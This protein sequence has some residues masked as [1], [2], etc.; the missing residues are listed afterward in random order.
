MRSCEVDVGRSQDGTAAETEVVLDGGEDGLNAR[1]SQ[2]E[3]H[4]CTGAEKG[5]QSKVR[6]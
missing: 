2:R 4:G 3:V 1:R 6:H 5:K